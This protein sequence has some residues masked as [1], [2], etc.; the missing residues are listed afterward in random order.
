MTFMD[1]LNSPKSDFTQNRSSSKIIKFQQS[2]ALTL[3]FAIFWSIVPLRLLNYD[4]LRKEGER[5]SIRMRLFHELFTS[6]LVTSNDDCLDLCEETDK[7]KWISFDSKYWECY[8]F[9]DCQKIDVESC[10]SCIS[11][12]SECNAPTCDLTGYC[13][14]RTYRIS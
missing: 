6:F 11:S 10:G 12:Q 1:R 4:I 14:V 2:Q 8:L 5:T 13:Q 9:E 7:C 3:H